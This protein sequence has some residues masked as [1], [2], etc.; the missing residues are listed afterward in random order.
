MAIKIEIDVDLQDIVPGFLEN[1]SKDLVELHRAVDESDLKTI[2]KIGHKVAGS[3]G[4]YGFDELGKMAKELELKAMDGKFEECVEL[5]NKIETHLK[6][7]EVV[8]VEME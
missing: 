6:N 3:S 5:I 2:E 1:R 7:V 4:G 8:F